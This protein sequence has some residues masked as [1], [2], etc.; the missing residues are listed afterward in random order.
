MDLVLCKI[1]YTVI[2][3]FLNSLIGSFVVMSSLTNNNFYVMSDM[4][5]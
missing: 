1:I 5:T 4:K 2:T 3:L